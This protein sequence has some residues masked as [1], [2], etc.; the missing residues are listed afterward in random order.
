MSKREYL[1][2]QD[3]ANS[4]TAV[5]FSPDSSTL[6]SASADNTIVL[7]NVGEHRLQRIGALT[8]HTDTVIGASF[9]PDGTTLVSA[10]LD[11]TAVL[12]DTNIESWRTRACALAW[13]NL[14][15]DE[16]N[17]NLPGTPYR[18]ICPNIPD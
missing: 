2:K 1:D 8:G 4:V 13:R 15:T 9:G 3:H 10:S 17:E 16:W 7:W 5:T 14:D 11:G 12:W 6:A 18:K